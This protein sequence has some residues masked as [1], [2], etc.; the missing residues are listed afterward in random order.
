MDLFF[1]FFNNKTMSAVVVI[2]L[3]L[4]VLLSLIAGGAYWWFN[5]RMPECKD[6]EELNEDKK[7]CERKSYKCQFIKITKN[8]DLTASYDGH[9]SLHEF[10]AY[11]ENGINVALNKTTS[12]SS[13]NDN[14]LPNWGVDGNKENVYHTGKD[15][16]PEWWQVNLGQEYNITSI[17]IF[18]QN[19]EPYSNR[20]NGA[21]IELL[22]KDGTTV[23]HTETAETLD[24]TKEKPYEQV[25]NFDATTETTETF[26]NLYSNK[27]YSFL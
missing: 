16:Q 20:M 10:E 15:T 3:S 21:T 4:C 2:L 8:N 17:K 13:N 11:N 23:V 19:A 14:D 5:I 7:K 22:A 25:F 26:K 9:L 18:R 12:S 6:G 27:N 1:L 24:K